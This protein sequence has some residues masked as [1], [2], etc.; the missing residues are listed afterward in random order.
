MSNGL[1]IAEV[2]ENLMPEKTIIEQSNQELAATKSRNVDRLQ[3]I[4]FVLAVKALVLLFAGQTFQTLADQKLV[5]LVDW[6]NIWHRWDA[7]HYQKLAEFGYSATGAL[8]PSMVFYP[9]YPWLI[10][11]L[12]F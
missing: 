6:L 9:L 11:F 7:L 10:R 8:R 3:I 5:N 2:L 12:H 4:A 1:G